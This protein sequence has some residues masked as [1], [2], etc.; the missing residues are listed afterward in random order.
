[1]GAAVGSGVGAA[2]SLRAGPVEPAAAGGAA[3]REGL[4]DEA[5]ASNWSSPAEDPGGGFGLEA[6]DLGLAVGAGFGRGARGSK[7]EG[8][9]GTDEESSEADSVSE[10]GTVPPWMGAASPCFLAG[11]WTS[12]EVAPEFVD[13]NATIADADT[14]RIPSRVNPPFKPFI[15]VSRPF[16]AVPNPSPR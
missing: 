5:G 11:I 6:G 3:P 13:R 12:R 7:E 2:E 8:G 16:P 14:N 9:E 1:M 4:V 15:R 10:S